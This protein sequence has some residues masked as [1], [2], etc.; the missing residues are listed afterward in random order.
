VPSYLTHVFDRVFVAMKKELT[1]RSMLRELG[2]GSVVGIAALS[3]AASGSVTAKQ[4]NREFD[5][6]FDPY[7]IEEVSGIADEFYQLPERKKATVVENLSDEQAEALADI[8]RPVQTTVKETA[9]TGTKQWD[10]FTQKLQ[11]VGVGAGHVTSGGR[12]RVAKRQTLER[13]DQKLADKWDWEKPT[14]ANSRELNEGTVT[15]GEEQLLAQ[16]TCLDEWYTYGAKV[17]YENYRGADL[18]EMEV[19][20]EYEVDIVDDVG[21]GCYNNK[22][23]EIRDREWGRAPDFGWSFEGFTSSWT[24]ERDRAIRAY[25]SAYFSGPN[26]G[27]VC[28]EGEPVLEISAGITGGGNVYTKKTGEQTKPACGF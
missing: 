19:E 9:L 25:R 1:R 22:F 11:S 2:S 12:Q 4:I 27:V 10:L 26:T 13:A 14:T 7:R 20:L 5:A 28:W 16:S 23:L 18:Y 3:G 15:N 8:K 21:P 24:E 17:T 6:D